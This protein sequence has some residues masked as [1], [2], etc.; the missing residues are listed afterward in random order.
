MYSGHASLCVCRSVRGRMPTLLHGPGCNFGGMVV[1]SRSCAL[2]AG[3]A[4]GARVALLWQHSANAKCQRMLV[5]AI[6]Q[7][8]Y[9]YYSVLAASAVQG[10][11]VLLWRL[12][13]HRHC[14]EAG[15]LQQRPRL[16]LGESEI[17]LRQPR[18]GNVTVVTRGYLSCVCSTV[19]FLGFEAGKCWSFRH[20]TRTSVSNTQT[21]SVT[22]TILHTGTPSYLAEI[23][24]LLFLRIPART[25]AIILFH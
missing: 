16:S 10:Y 23:A 14:Y 9:Y 17:Q 20:C 25:F 12:Q 5:L 13:R 15:L 7:V 8:I 19:S 11:D 3:F 6:C 1:G 4:I 24:E 22:Y 18:T 21:E 2:L